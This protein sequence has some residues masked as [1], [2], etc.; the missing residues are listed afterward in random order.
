MS[1]NEWNTSQLMEGI[2]AEYLLARESLQVGCVAPALRSLEHLQE[3]TEA[4]HEC[5]LNLI[6]QQLLVLEPLLQHLNR[7]LAKLATEGA[8]SGKGQTP[9]RKEGNADGSKR[10]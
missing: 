1:G 4:L 9:G 6:R 8:S 2:R 3:Q 5:H 7:L 10:S